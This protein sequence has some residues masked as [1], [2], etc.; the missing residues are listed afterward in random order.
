MGILVTRKASQK[1]WLACALTRLAAL[2]D[3]FFLLDVGHD[4]MGM[5]LAKNKQQIPK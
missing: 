4:S 1:L 3:V 2:A 5:L